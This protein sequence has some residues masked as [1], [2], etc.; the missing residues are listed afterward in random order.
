MNLNREILEKQFTGKEI[1]QRKGNFG[2]QIDYVE[3]QLVIQRLNDA[4]DGLWSFKVLEHEIIGDEAIVLGELSC[5]GITKQQFGNSKITVSKKGEVVSTGDDLKA[6]ASDSLKKCAVIFGVGLHLYGDSIPSDPVE[7]STQPPPAGKE[8]IPTAN[9]HADLPKDTEYP[10]PK[11]KLPPMDFTEQ[12]ELPPSPPDKP[13]LQRM[14][15]TYFAGLPEFL[16]D[17][18]TRY[19]WQKKNI[20]KISTKQWDEKDFE[21]ALDMTDALNRETSDPEA[22]KELPDIKSG[23]GKFNSENPMSA[24]Q[25]KAIWNMFEKKGYFTNEDMAKW[26]I[27]KASAVIEFLN[28]Q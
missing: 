19:D 11:E 22:K 16:K 17:E 24:N 7:N 13:R 21:R 20:G 2:A 5:N 18:A 8:R 28:Q 12:T 3:V 9:G 27:G 26:T 6:A 4:F 10:K 14:K 1:K 23:N 25:T 15:E